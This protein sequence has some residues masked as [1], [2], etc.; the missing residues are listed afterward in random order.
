MNDEKR[1]EILQ[2]EF[3]RYHG[4]FEPHILSMESLSPYEL[5]VEL[6]DGSAI[7]FDSLYKT[8]VTMRRGE[9][10][11]DEEWRQEFGRRLNR[12]L[13]KKGMV[14]ETLAD[15][16]GISRQMLGKYMNGKAVPSARNISKLS[17]VL[18]CQTSDLI[19]ID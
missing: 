5:K 7:V 12:A 16:V 4:Y 18:D 9:V 10:V 6:D 13:W 1:L 3:L 8:V 19:D 17:R 2:N 11:T 14:Q 15:E